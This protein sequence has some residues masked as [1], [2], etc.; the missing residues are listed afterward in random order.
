MYLKR[1]FTPTL[2]DALAQIREELGPDA[3]VLST[4][5]VRQAGWRG[6]VG[7]RGLEVTAAAE[8]MVSE[9]RT[10]PMS[11]RHD[12]NAPPLDAALMARLCATGMDKN[13]AQ[14][15]AA[16]M[17]PG[18]RGASLT[19]LR[20]TLATRLAEL[21]PA[22]ESPANIQVFVGPPGVGKTTTIAKIAAQQRARCGPRLHLVSADAYRVGAIEQLRLYADI[23]GA[24]FTAARTPRDLD[25]ALTGGRGPVLVDTAGRS[26]DD[27]SAQELWDVLAKHRGVQTHL[28]ASAGTGARELDQIFE[29]YQVAQPSRVVLT[30]IDEASSL[31][32][33]V[34]VLRHRKLPISY[35]GTGQRVPEDL[36]RATGD[37]LAAC[38]IGDRVAQ[39]EGR[40]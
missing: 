16:A 31:S 28:V 4:R 13:L 2:R 24:S 27:G 10:D 29:R 23:V 7:G 38:V 25:E 39:Q 22:D 5:T 1:Y 15:V 8:R 36:Q 17:P 18:R 37:L 26:P 32:P 12:K 20:G 30:K 6:W 33:L 40:R 3:L 14:E 19:D 34:G 9:S 35:L 11:R 21:A